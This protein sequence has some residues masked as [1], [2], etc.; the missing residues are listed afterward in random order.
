[1]IAMVADLGGMPDTEMD[2]DYSFLS[3]NAILI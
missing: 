2:A 3:H 1:M